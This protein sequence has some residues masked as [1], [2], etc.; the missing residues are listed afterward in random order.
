[1]VQFNRGLLGIILVCIYWQSIFIFAGSFK[2]RSLVPNEA[3]TNKIIFFI[4]YVIVSECVKRLN[5]KSFCPNYCEVDHRHSFQQN[6]AG[7]CTFCK[8][9]LDSYMFF[10]YFLSSVATSVALSDS[11]GGS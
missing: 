9:R 2:Y 11:L 6:K 7:K 1:M 8:K 4:T 5:P 10:D 3:D